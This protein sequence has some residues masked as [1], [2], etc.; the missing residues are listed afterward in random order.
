[1]NSE[2]TTPPS[3]AN[4]DYLNDLWTRLGMKTPGEPPEEWP[5][6]IA[7]REIERISDPNFISQA[8]VF[9]NQKLKEKLDY[10]EFNRIWS[11]LV[12]AN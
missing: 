9:I 6:Q 5:S 10:Q 3:L 2:N 4:L 7:K 8:R 11:L 12:R 1:M